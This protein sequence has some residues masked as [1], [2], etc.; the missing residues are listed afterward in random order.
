MENK[1]VSKNFWWIVILLISSIIAALCAAFFGKE[2]LAVVFGGAV[3]VVFSVLILKEPALG[4]YVLAFLL[5]FERIGS[6]DFSDIT[7]RPSQIFALI[8]LVAWVINFLIKRENFSAKNPI[9]VPVACFLGVSIL[10]I[11]NTQNIG[12]ALFVFGFNAFVILMSLMLPNLINDERTLRR[13]IFFVLLAAVAV[14]LFGMYQFLG[15]ISGL[16]PELT[17]LRQHYTSEV[18]GF[19]RIQST[20]LEPLYFANYLFIPLGL[21][22]VFLF[23]S[24]GRRKKEEKQK[25]FP[26]PLI[27][28]ILVSL[29]TI[30]LILTLS[31]GAYIGFV[32]FLFL[33][34]IIFW[35]QLFSLKRII[36][37]VLIIAAAFLVV[38]GF[39][40]FAGKAK[41]VQKF[42]NQ[43]TNFSAHESVAVSERYGTY[44]DAIEMIKTRPFLGFGP[45]S[46]GPYVAV[47]ENIAPRGGWLIVNNILLEIWAEEGLF[48][49]IFFIIIFVVLGIRTIKAWRVVAK[50]DKLYLKGA[51]LGLAIALVAMLVQY[52]TFSILYI[53]HFWFL[54]GLLVSCQNLILHTNNVRNI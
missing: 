10:S 3:A 53:F 17:G 39:L 6:F 15:D 18:F 24:L 29:F 19:P 31:R 44:D 42:I 46:F 50:A 1:F 40:N 5:P 4:I 23:L 38:L 25:I 13:T 51:L 36:A 41:S 2:A 16:P 14:S 21:T 11:I 22:L 43:A 12:R 37:I 52:Q 20:F 7:I 32:V 26:N 54:I 28:I 34:M 9:I 30:N 45:G 49:L 27:L 48:G 8:T 47:S 35:R 33:I